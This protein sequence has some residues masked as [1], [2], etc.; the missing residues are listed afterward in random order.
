M[1]ASASSM[2]VM[3]AFE[4][5]PVSLASDI[6]P[7]VRRRRI[8]VLVSGGLAV[9]GLVVWAAPDAVREQL[10]HGCGRLLKNR[11]RTSLALSIRL[12]SA[13]ANLIA[14]IAIDFE[15]F[16]KSEIRLSM[17]KLTSSNSL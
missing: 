11:D 8:E 4:R 12:F 10:R 6:G 16:I 14:E 2:N 5:S 17:Q 13:I 7:G 15:L 3:E 1:Q 9:V